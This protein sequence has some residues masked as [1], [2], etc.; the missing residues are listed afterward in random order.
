MSGGL[1]SYTAAAIA[2]EQR[3]TLFALTVLYGGQALNLVVVSYTDRLNFAFTA[4]ADSLP[5]VQ[6]LATHCRAAL[7]ELEHTL[8]QRNAQ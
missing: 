3:F 2:K 1:D 5:H 4:C 8:S 6:R 7:V